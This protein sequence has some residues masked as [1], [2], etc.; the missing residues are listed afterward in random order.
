[1]GNSQRSAAQRRVVH[2]PT[3]YAAG[4]TRVCYT[5]STDTQYGLTDII[6]EQLADIIAE[7]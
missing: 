3:A 5:G 2:I 7:Q 6:A 4:P 1:M